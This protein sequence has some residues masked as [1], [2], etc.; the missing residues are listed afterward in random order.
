MSDY[1]TIEKRQK[2]HYAKFAFS[3]SFNRATAS[4]KVL[5]AY[6]DSLIPYHQYA[7]ERSK[8]L[9]LGCGSHVPAFARQS[10][11][12]IVGLDLSDEMLS[13]LKSQYPA[14]PL[15]QGSGF[16]LP[17]QSHS[18]SI[19]VARGSLHH[20]PDLSRISSQISQALTDN[21]IL[22]FLEPFNDWV[23]WRV[24]RSIVYSQSSQLD[25]HSEE[26]LR[27]ESFAMALDSF[28]ISIT[29]I[30]PSGLATFVLLRN[31]DISLLSALLTA[32]PIFPYVFR[33]TLFLD[34]LLE[35]L[36]A[37]HRWIFPELAGTA[38]KRSRTG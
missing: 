34:R 12:F 35:R 13:I 23:V 8:V 5:Q 29:S 11:S 22:V 18:L 6:V 26:A 38:K 27:Y 1:R 4:V 20:M 10:R 33:L 3:Y 19:I 15:V 36:F 37:R 28:G 14:L 21:G 32:A 7:T 31:S 25:Q 2:K 24:L 17:F 9:L 30:Q 16:S